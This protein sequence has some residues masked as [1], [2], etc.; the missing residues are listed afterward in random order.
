[1]AGYG[2]LDSPIFTTETKL[3]L[4]FLQ[5]IFVFQTKNSPSKV[6]QLLSWGGKSFCNSSAALLTNI[7]TS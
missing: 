7:I 5:L 4:M 2:N 6:G 1:M 3:S